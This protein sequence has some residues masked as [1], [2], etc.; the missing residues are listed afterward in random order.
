M[1]LQTIHL[2][3]VIM[4]HFDSYNSIHT[5]LIYISSLVLLRHGGFL[6]VH[7][8]HIY[9]LVYGILLYSY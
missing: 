3:R 4:V 9:L 5:L 1:P 7:T 8:T 2:S 6:D